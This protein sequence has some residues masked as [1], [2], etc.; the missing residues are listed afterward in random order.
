LK[1]STFFRDY[2]FCPEIIERLDI[3]E[4]VR[5]G[6][7]RGKLTYSRK[8]VEAWAKEMMGKPAFS[9]SSRALRFGTPAFSQNTPA[10]G[11][12]NELALVLSAH[13]TGL[14][15]AQE[16]VAARRDLASKYGIPLD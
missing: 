2:R 1:R 12:G 11:Y 14:I 10:R 13:R 5:D 4:V 8:A 9:V 3:R 6:Q 16:C 7:V 15:T